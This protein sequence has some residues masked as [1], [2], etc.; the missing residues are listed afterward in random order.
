[1]GGFVRLKGEDPSN[2]EEF[3]AKDSFIKAKV[4]N[5][6]L[7]LIA[8]V[9]MNFLVARFLFS[10]MFFLGTKP[11][12]L[13]PENA[14]KAQSH[15]YLMPTLSFLQAQGF[16]SGDITAIPPKI[17]EVIPGGIGAAIGLK[18]GDVLLSVNNE[19]V[20]IINIGDVLKKHI[21][22]SI[23]I[24][25]QRGGI[26]HSLNGECNAEDCLLGISFALSGDFSI[27]DIKFPL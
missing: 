26:T 8:G 15:S 5:K 13:L 18:S 4:R 17:E 16:T 2:E 23:N 9:G 21:G 27:K 14:L 12:S 3:H 7:I 19:S 1:L 25:Y 20:N 6:I 10:L 11:I 24:D 22:K